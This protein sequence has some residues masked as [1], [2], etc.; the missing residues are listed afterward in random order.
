LLS[1]DLEATHVTPAS[2]EFCLAD[3]KVRVEAPPG[4]LAVL[5]ATLSYVPRFST[6]ST[7]DIVISAQPRTDVWEIRGPDGSLKVLGAQSAL[8]QVAGAVVSS[9]VAEVA[10]TQRYTAMRASVV[11]KDGRALAMVGD[12][13]ESAIT[14]A[15]HLHGRGWSYLGSDNVFLDEHKL[16]VF[17]IQKSLYVNS[18][19][20]AQFPIEYRRAVEASPW[21]VT[22]QGISFYAVDPRRA[23]HV[24]TWAPSAKLDGVIVVDGLMA[25]CAS[26][27]SLE[28]RHLKADRFVRL[29]LDWERVPVA[30]LCIGGFVDTADLIEHWFESIRL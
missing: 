26:L 22:A 9:A 2:L 3:T 12:D 14:L 5:D 20:I 17:S 15:A 29:G 10:A 28:E 6:R 11:Q 21:Y 18:S 4:V 19:S 7:A 25:D 27:E 1:R 8:P 13:W 30:E 23:G 16:D 24:Q